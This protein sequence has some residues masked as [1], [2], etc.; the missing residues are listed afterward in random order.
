MKNIN[1]FFKPA[2]AI[3]CALSLLLAIVPTVIFSALALDKDNQDIDV[4]PVTGGDEE[5]TSE[6]LLINGDFENNLE[7]WELSDNQLNLSA[8][9]EDAY[10]GSFSYKLN[11]QVENEVVAKQIVSLEDKV[12]Y[13]VSWYAK[14]VSG[15]GEWDISIKSESG[16]SRISL[17]DGA[18]SFAPDGDGW[19]RYYAHFWSSEWKKV[20]IGFY[21]KTAAE[22]VVLV[23]NVQIT[24]LQDNLLNGGCEDDTGWCF[25]NDGGNQSG[26]STA[27]AHSGSSS[28]VLYGDTMYKQYAFQWVTVEPNTYYVI[29]F[30][31]LR[32]SKSSG[33][34]AVLCHNGKASG[35]PQYQCTLGSG[36]FSQVNKDWTPQSFV[37]Y[38]GESTRML[39]KMTPMTSNVPKFY[40]DDISMEVYDP[41]LLNGG[42]EDGLKYWT[43]CGRTGSND[44]SFVNGCTISSDAYTGVSSLKLNAT[45]GQYKE[46]VSQQ[47][48]VEK[49]TDYTISWYTKRLSGD[50]AWLLYGVNSAYQTLKPKYG[51]NFFKQTDTENWYYCYQVI[52]T[53]DS[54]KLMIKLSPEGIDGA[55]AFLIDDITISKTVS[56]E[57]NSFEE[58]TSGW[59][60]NQDSANLTARKENEANSGNCCLELNYPVEN[61]EAAGCYIDVEAN[62]NYLISWAAKRSD[63]EGTWN[64]LVKSS[65][66]STVLEPVQGSQEFKKDEKDWFTYSQIINTGENTRIYLSFVNVT[67]D[68]TVYFIDDINLSEKNLEEV[69]YG[70]LN[71]GFENGDT[72]WE[73]AGG[74]KIVSSAY[75]GNKALD[76]NQ[77]AAGAVAAKQ[78]F[79]VKSNT[80]YVILFY[81]RRATQ[82]S[83]WNV[84]LTDP[85]NNNQEVTYTTGHTFYDTD[86]DNWY[87]YTVEFN[88]GDSNQLT[89]AFSPT[90]SNVAEYYIDDIGAYVKGTEPAAETEDTEPLKLT[91]F[92]TVLNRPTDE[93]YNLIKNGDFEATDD[94]QWNVSTFLD[95]ELK[96]VE[97][98]NAKSGSKSLYFDC[99]ADDTE[100][101]HIFWVDVEPGMDYT[102][103]AFVKGEYLDSTNKGNACFGVIDVHNNKFLCYDSYYTRLSN[104]N[105]QIEPTAWDNNWH[106]RSVTFNTEAKSKVGIAVYGS[107]SRMWID[108]MALYLSENGVK[109]TTDKVNNVVSV[110]YNV[111][112]SYCS[113][114][115][116]LITDATIST[117][118]GAEFWT[119]GAGWKNGFMSIR[120]SK[121]EYGT[122]LKYIAS[123]E[124]CGISYIKWIEIEPDVD[125]T[126]SCDMKIL[127][128]GEGYMSLLKWEKSGAE[129]F[130]QFDFDTDVYGEDWVH[131]AINIKSSNV[132]KLGIQVCDKGGVALLDN[133]RLFKTGVGVADGNDSFIPRPAGLDDNDNPI[134][135][136][137]DDDDDSGNTSPDTGDYM[138][139]LCA[140]L[141][142]IISAATMVL[143]SRKK[144]FNK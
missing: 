116:N 26:Y 120:K 82:G 112:K 78:T 69:T 117:S 129:D 105:L 73:L 80:D 76:L 61:G 110:N 106:L 17:F 6:N 32:A 144:K 97:D 55:T 137:D 136:D 9:D 33:T 34:W 16:T 53:G 27:K 90:G 131:T 48:M 134:I 25:V 118:A 7:G 139:M 130:I 94:A 142:V 138:S 5:T 59:D 35:Y 74:S 81:A 135:T 22:N 77:T 45:N 54:E 60:I 95:D 123:D 29:S 8:L 109:Y 24:R 79:N 41:G 87:R 39:V 86:R 125:Y 133:L 101:W 19:T 65:D 15:E 75:S 115:D 62:K 64:L 103:S 42:F 1:K 23:D 51:K 84:S 93:Q 88:S 10:S 107:N 68:D 108:G 30:W 141:A 122:S 111:D 28:I 2:I 20:Q 49:N 91:S 47:I 132:T 3:I 21:S 38:S 104:E 63:G 96:V 12:D 57:N 99:S 52:N 98:E 58:D 67:G 124:P 127:E 43:M 113:D 14:R 100:K 126:F 83:N 37:V 36:G 11:C 114:A 46:A 56:V 72:S 13:V 70:I 89:I 140:N 121:Y 92:G 18:T 71:G 128:N 66:K 31:T 102:F 44:S 40:I 4:L 85:D 143:L 119:S 50:T